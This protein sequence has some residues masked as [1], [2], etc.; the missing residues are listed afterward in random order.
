[1]AAADSGRGQRHISSRPRGA[2]L[3][4]FKNSTTKG[5]CLGRCRC[6][7]RG[8]TQQGHAPGT[9]QSH[10]PGWRPQKM[11]PASPVLIF[12]VC[13]G[14][15]LSKASCGSKR[16]LAGCSGMRMEP[17][18]KPQSSPGPQRTAGSWQSWPQMFSTCWFCPCLKKE[19]GTSQVSVTPPSP[20]TE[21]LVWLLNHVKYTLKNDFYSILMG[22]QKH[23]QPLLKPFLRAATW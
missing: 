4:C 13:A 1:M 6:A 3:W 7:A 17:P 19:P 12:R 9:A 11:S 16:N 10:R 20:A 18:P 8:L 2:L 15:L 22:T 23:P 21:D 5:G 14:S